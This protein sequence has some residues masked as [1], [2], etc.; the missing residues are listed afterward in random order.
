[1]GIGSGTITTGPIQT[2]TAATTGTIIGT[3]ID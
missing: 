2:A 3:I 1:M